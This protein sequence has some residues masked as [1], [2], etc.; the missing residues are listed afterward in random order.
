MTTV[1]TKAIMQIKGFMVCYIAKRT[2]N[3]QP[4]FTPH[5]FPSWQSFE[6]RIYCRRVIKRKSMSNPDQ[7]IPVVAAENLRKCYGSFVAVND[8]S[9]T[10]GRGELFGILGPNGAG[11]TSTIRMIYGFSPLSGGSLTVFGSNVTTDW[12]TIRARLGVCHQD[13]NLDT[14]MSVRQ[15]LEVFGTF[16][17]IPA[18][19]ARKRAT[20]L[21]EFFGLAHREK[22]RVGELSGGLMRR[23]VL[24]RA[25]INEPELLILDEPT[26]G[27]DPQSRQQLWEQ[28]ARLKKRGVTILLT[29]HYMEEAAQLCDRLIIID[30]GRILVEGRPRDL[31]GEYVG[32]QVIE[33][34]PVC[35]GLRE[36]VKTRKLDVEDLGHRLLI[37]CKNDEALYREITGQ[38]CQDNCILRMGTLEDVFLKL[39]GRELRE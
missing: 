14:E 34:S 4:N 5:H 2:A 35:E 20:E 16:F 11:K 7:S 33:S 9:F 1:H 12:R 39:T 27:L 19:T 30:R 24:A 8:I 17:G 15:N 25:L 21:L 23:L 32:H 13:N 22:A 3:I 38:Y 6:T 36:F 26:T 31:V 37:Y 18:P 28:L 10:V 29:T